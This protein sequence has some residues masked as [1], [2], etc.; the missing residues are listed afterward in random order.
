MSGDPFSSVLDRFG[1]RFDADVM[2]ATVAHWQPRVML[3]RPAQSPFVE[4]IAYGED[5][6]H[7]MDVFPVPRTAAQ[8]VLFVHGG[9]FNA[10]DKNVAPP[11][12]SNVGHYFASHGILAACMNYRLAPSG[13]WPAAAEDVDLAVRWLV[14]RGDLYGGDPRKLVV[15]G[16]SAGACHVAT[17]LFEPRFKGG[18]RETLHGAVLMSGL[19]LAEPPLTPG[20]QAYFG[21]DEKLYRQR[22]PLQMVSALP[23]PVLVTQAGNDPA[24][25]R[26]N[27]QAMIRA[28]DHSGTTASFAELAKH[29]HVSPLMSLGSDNDEVG[30]L[31]RNFIVSSCSVVK[32]PK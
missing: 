28:L 4:D 25:L 24:Q 5:A 27:S 29:N 18:P 20:R 31:L 13:G 22:S 15:I 19:Y 30:S 9:G 8:M 16:Q 12:Y 10:G 23:Y 3:N 32:V 14:D 21:D 2:K 17:W 26:Q 1:S 6:R 11:F 7:Y